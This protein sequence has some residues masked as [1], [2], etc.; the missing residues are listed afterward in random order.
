MF[1]GDGFGSWMS[2]VR[3]VHTGDVDLHEVLEQSNPDR[4][5]GLWTSQLVVAVDGSEGMRGSKN[6]A[7]N[8]G[9][10]FSSCKECCTR[11]VS[12]GLVF[13]GHM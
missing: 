7:V 6:G 4:G 13:L 1:A 9:K 2:T 12:V 3:L 10:S 8:I 5:V 11:T